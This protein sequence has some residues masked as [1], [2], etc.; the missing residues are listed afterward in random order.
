MANVSYRVGA[1]V[2]TL[3]GWE[4][5][6]T[7]TGLAGAGIDKGTLPTYT[8]TDTPTS[9]TT[10][11][12]KKITHSTMFCA[13]GNIT[14]DRCWFAPSGASID[15][16]T[17]YV[18]GYDPDF[19]ANQ[20]GDVTFLDCDLDGTAITSSDVFHTS[21]FRGAGSL[22]RCNIFGFGGA[23]AYVGSPTVTTSTI[24]HC[25]CHDNRGGMFGSPAQQSHNE[26]V[27]V[28]NFGGTSFNVRNNQFLSFTGS[29]TGA[30]FIQC[31]A[32]VNNMTLE[33]NVFSSNGYNLPLEQHGSSYSNLVC[34]NN[35]FNP[36][37]FGYGY[38]DGGAGWNT[39]T[40]N[41][42]WVPANPNQAGAVVSAP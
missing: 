4:L 22:Y 13:A 8:G 20:L 6:A 18:Y 21:A 25:Y 7:N 1:A 27:F 34:N 14:F 35:R 41:F 12:L 33:G 31:W 32:P 42:L 30:F 29:D 37:D 39:W 15:T 40:N 9:G 23:I 2:G 28:F 24:E 19:A 5:N 11:T 16:R 36:V 10:I 17:G 38:V 26:A 3:F